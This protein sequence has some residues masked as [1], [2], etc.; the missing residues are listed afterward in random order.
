MS[1]RSGSSS[2]MRP[3]LPS[4]RRRR[5]GWP[6]TA[7][8]KPPSPHCAGVDALFMVSAAES[9]TRREEHRTFI[10]AAAEAGVGTSSTPRSSGRRRTPSSPWAVTTGTRRSRSPESGMR[11]TLL[12]DNF[13]SDLLPYFADDAGVIRGPAGE[14]RVAAVA[15]AD[16]ADVAVA[17]LR[18]LASHVDATYAADRPGSADHGR[19]R[20][21]GRRGDRSRAEL[22][23]RDDR[24]GVRV[25]RRRSVRSSGSSTRGS[26]PTW[27]SPRGEVAAVSRRRRTPDRPP[28]PATGG[29]TR[30]RDLTELTSETG[31]ELQLCGLRC[32]SLRP[33]FAHG[34]GRNAGGAVGRD[35]W[36]GRRPAGQ[37]MP[38]C[39]MAAT[40]ARTS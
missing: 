34:Q 31:R 20:R 3:V 14:G 19:D 13:Y 27:R 36:A 5:S 26:V 40:R 4:C 37:S 39:T 35:D 38:S 11:H 30:R 6:R 18:D 22:P 10:A 29:G 8:G 15:R 16:V 12:R 9:A 24:R 17:V 32:C 2:A 7:T 23:R 33:L 25:A 21:P 1:S 28:G